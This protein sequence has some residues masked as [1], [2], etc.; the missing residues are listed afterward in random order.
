MSKKLKDIRIDGTGFNVPYWAGKTLEEFKAEAMKP[1]AAM[2]PPDVP[3]KDREKWCAT[4]HGLIVKANNGEGNP[5]VNTE[6]LEAEA[7]AAEKT[8]KKPAPGN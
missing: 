8:K 4:A 3:E 1:D 7:A 2:I 5:V 6:E